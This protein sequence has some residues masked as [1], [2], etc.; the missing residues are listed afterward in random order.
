MLSSVIRLGLGRSKTNLPYTVYLQK[1]PK[2]GPR[3]GKASGSTSSCH[4]EAKW[5]YEDEEKEA[6]R[7]T[8]EFRLGVANA[9]RATRHFFRQGLGYKDE[10]TMSMS[11][12]FIADPTRH[13]NRLAFRRTVVACKRVQNGDGDGALRDNANG[14]H[15]QAA[16]AF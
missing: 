16:G 3:W 6:Q 13:Q 14:E 4:D 8:H 11:I 2:W 7:E 5:R 12:I 1:I 10:L 9:I 15:K